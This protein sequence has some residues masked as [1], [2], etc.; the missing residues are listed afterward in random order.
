[1]ATPASLRTAGLGALLSVLVACTPSSLETPTEPGL[2]PLLEGGSNPCITEASWA[3]HGDPT[4]L[5]WDG[6]SG[7]GGDADVEFEV[8]ECPDENPNCKT[9]TLS[10][11]ERLTCLEAMQKFKSSGIC[12]GMRS[13]AE[14]RLNGGYVKTWDYYFGSNGWYLAADIHWRTLF[15]V[16]DS[17]ARLHIYAGE[18]NSSYSVAMRVGHEYMHAYS[19]TKAHLPNHSTS[20]I[21]CIQ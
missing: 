12:A 7:G 8:V 20:V 13:W 16:N 9:R 3:C 21:D 19:N 1:M 10:S 11:S 14:G 4:F 6:S 2:N 18:F 17:R 15:G 5:W